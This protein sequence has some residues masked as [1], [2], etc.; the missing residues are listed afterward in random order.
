MIS[1]SY[2]MMIVLFSNLCGT[3]QSGTICPLTK[4]S[5]NLVPGVSEVVEQTGVFREGGEKF[6]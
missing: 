5:D 4:L 3:P 1:N 2:E 6:L